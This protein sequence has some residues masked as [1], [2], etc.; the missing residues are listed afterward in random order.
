MSEIFIFMEI[1]LHETQAKVPPQMRQIYFNQ[2]LICPKEKTT[3]TQDSFFL[4][5]EF[6]FYVLQNKLNPHLL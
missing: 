3:K 2:K 1:S 5:S 4:L 6:V